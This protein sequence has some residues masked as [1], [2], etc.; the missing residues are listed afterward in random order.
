M[1]VSVLPAYMNMHP[2]ANL[3]PTEVSGFLEPGLWMFV[4]RCMGAETW[5]QVQYSLQVHLGEEPSF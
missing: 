1:S 4:K 3:V 5:T 2:H